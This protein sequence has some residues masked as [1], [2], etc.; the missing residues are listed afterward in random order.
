MVVAE[1]DVRAEY[2]CVCA[3]CGVVSDSRKREASL[4]GYPLENPSSV[5]GNFP[6]ACAS[7]SLCSNRPT[8]AGE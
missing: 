3:C 4:G 8:G 1:G 7:P 2:V 6:L 5:R